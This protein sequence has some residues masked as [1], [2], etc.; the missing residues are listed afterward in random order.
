MQEPRADSYC[1]CNPVC[2]FGIGIFGKTNIWFQD[3]KPRSLGANGL[4]GSLDN[5]SLSGPPPDSLH[6]QDN[7]EAPNPNPVDTEDS[8]GSPGD[9]DIDS[10]HTDDSEPGEDIGSLGLM[11]A[12]LN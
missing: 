8:C 7:I 5:I 6:S 1:E 2:V 3:P 10:M 11:F 12:S 4:S 9:S